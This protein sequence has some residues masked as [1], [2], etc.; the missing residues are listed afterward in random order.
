MN[1]DRYTED[2]P[3]SFDRILSN[4]ADWAKAQE[5]IQAAI[6]IGSQARSHHPADRWSDL[7]LVIYTEETGAYLDNPT[8]IDHFGEVW[9]R[10]IDQTD[11]GDPEWFIFFSGGLKVDILLVDISSLGGDDLCQ[12]VQHSA[13]ADVFSRGVRVV[14]DKTASIGRLP[15]ILESGSLHLPDQEDLDNLVQKFLLASVRAARLLHRKDLWRARQACDEDLKVHL[16][17]MLEF[18]ALASDPARQD[19]W[20]DG[21]F[22]EEWVDPLIFKRLPAC[23]GGFDIDSLWYAFRNTISLFGDLGMQTSA[24]LKLKYPAEISQKILGWIEGDEQNAV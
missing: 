16:L 3:N 5:P 17:R 8:W 7:D 13:F 18:H 15:I 12:W 20:Y 4:F 2:N 24:R 10:A 1:H 11:R 6:V 14:L 23:F 21:R 22:L 9:A 19:I